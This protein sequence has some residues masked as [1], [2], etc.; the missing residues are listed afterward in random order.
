MIISPKVLPL[1]QKQVSIEEFSS[2]VYLDMANWCGFYGY[3]ES[4]SYYRGR[5]AEELTHRDKIFQFLLDCNYQVALI[6]IP[7]P[8]YSIKEL[9]D[10]I[11][12]ALTHE[13]K[14]SKAILDIMKAAEEAEDFN[15]EQF[16]LWFVNE[17]R[18]EES[19]YI[20]LIDWATKLGLY[21]SAPDW[22]KGIM[23]AQLDEY[24]GE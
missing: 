2:R 17:Q 21:S 11:K 1:V 6:D 23:R 5:A 7:K 24:I 13:Q 8:D 16:F 4:E 9:E 20:D 15:A 14:V 19:T 18:E 10:T 12:N 3:K 22:A